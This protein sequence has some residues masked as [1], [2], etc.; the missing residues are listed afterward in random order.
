MTV[1]AAAVLS[2][3]LALSFGVPGAYGAW[4]FADRGVVWTF[5]GFPTYGDGPFDRAGV[6]TTTPLLIAFVLVCLLEAVL[7]WL[8]WRHRRSGGILALA[9]LPAE[10]MFWIGFALPLGPVVGAARTAL[11]VAGWSS[12]GAATSVAES[13]AHR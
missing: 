5:L 4:Y 9:L 3:L 12:L 2:W 7:G 8:L 1:R 10:V 11:V 6:E 13:P